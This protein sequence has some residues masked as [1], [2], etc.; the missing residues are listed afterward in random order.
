MFTGI[1]L[2]TINL[3]IFFIISRNLKP[4]TEKLKELD[5]VTY[6][7]LSFTITTGIW[8]LYFISN[9]KLVTDYAI[10]LIQSSKHI[11]ESEYNISYLSPSKFSFIFYAE[12]G[13]YADREYMSKDDWS[14]VIE[15][16]H[17]T[18]CGIFAC[19][20][21]VY[22]INNKIQHYNLTLGVSMGSQLM[23]SV[24]YIASYIY[25][26]HQPNSINYDSKSFPCGYA[27]SKRPFMYVNVFWSLMPTYILLYHIRKYNFSALQNSKII[28]M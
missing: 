25:Q 16:T 23:N 10:S 21:L 1:E 19:I 27:Y 2:G 26:T 3:V 11:W 14:R 22:L 5:C 9:Y 7:W 28:K 8:E 13:A 6:Y 20:A 24:L 15:G 12:Y 18:L 17:C 4:M